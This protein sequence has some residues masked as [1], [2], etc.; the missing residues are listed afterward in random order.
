MK[1]CI[2]PVICSGL[3]FVGAC[4]RKSVQ[5][6]SDPNNPSATNPAAGAPATPP[7]P[8]PVTLDA[9]TAFRVRL[10][11]TIDTQ[12]NRSGDRFTAELDEP[13]VS[14]DRVIVP[15]GTIF[16][17]RVVESKPSG[18]FKGR[19]VLA[20]RL[21]SFNLNGEVVNIDTSSA[22]RASKGHTGHNLKWIGGGT[23]G[24][25]AIGA[26]AGGGEGAAIGAGAGAAGGLIGSALTG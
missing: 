23:G 26:L 4:N 22:A 19:A 24:G 15:K 10:Q 20:L 16:S 17:G 25:A 7:A 5:A 8:P 21:D 14:G 6:A 11:E 2:L 9:G 3:L 12:R 18:R 1:N 13:L